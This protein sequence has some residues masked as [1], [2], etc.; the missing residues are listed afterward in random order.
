MKKNLLPKPPSSAALVKQ[1]AFE[2]A[3]ARAKYQ[4]AENIFKVVEDLTEEV[5]IGV[6]HFFPDEIS[7]RGNSKGDMEIDFSPRRSGRR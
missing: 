6:F 7:R 1:Y 2:Q 4:F 5:K 3:R